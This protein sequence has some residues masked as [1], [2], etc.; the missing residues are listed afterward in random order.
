MKIKDLL[1]K[2]QAP[3]NLVTSLTF[4]LPLFKKDFLYTLKV[5]F[6][7][8]KDVVTITGESVADQDSPIKSVEAVL[9]TPVRVWRK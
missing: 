2:P 8:N 1:V 6:K 7:K 4:D 9:K 3:D 5:A